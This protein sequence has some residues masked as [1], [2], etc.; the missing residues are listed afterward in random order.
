MC[1]KCPTPRLKHR[2]A[3]PDASAPLSCPL[4]LLP[5]AAGAQGWGAGAWHGLWGRGSRQQSR[6]H[7]VLTAQ[8]DPCPLSRKRV[9]LRRKTDDKVPGSH[10]PVECPAPS[11]CRGPSAALHFTV[12]SKLQLQNDSP[13]TPPPEVESSSRNVQSL[14]CPTGLPSS[15]PRPVTCW[16]CVSVS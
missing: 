5:P 6:A 11:G 14:R 16:C 9:D 10:L 3:S 7:P 15:G 2:I 8:E 13:V 1:P 12:F 4:C